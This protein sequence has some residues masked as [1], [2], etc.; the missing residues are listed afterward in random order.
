MFARKS[1]LYCSFCRK[2]DKEVTKLMAGPGVHICDACVSLCNDI[3]DGKQAGGF[4]G[5]ESLTDRQ[6]LSALPHSE[7]S[8]EASRRVLATQVGIL[9]SRGV[10]W[11]TIGK[12][13]GVSRQAA[14]E[15][16]S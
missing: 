8:V 16:F 11:E 6:L 14:W 1:H 12:A 10:S 3:L 13:L 9:R 2:S 5:W 7:A 15:R 4:A